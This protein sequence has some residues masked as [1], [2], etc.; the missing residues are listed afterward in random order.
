MRA[1]SLPRSHLTDLPISPTQVGLSSLFSSCCL[2]SPPPLPSCATALTP[3]GP[4]TFAARRA[5]LAATLADEGHAAYVSEPSANTLFYANLSASSWHLSERPFLLVTLPTTNASSK[6]EPTLVVVP[7][8][9]MT[10]AKLQLPLALDPAST[11]WLP[12]AEAED[13]YASL[14][15]Y[16]APSASAAIA[17]GRPVKVVVDENVRSGIAADLEAS[18]ARELGT[19]VRVMSSPSG[20]R[21]LRER[22]TTEEIDR[23][24]CAN[25]VLFVEVCPCRTSIVDMSPSPLP[26]SAHALGHPQ[27]EGQPRLWH[28]RARRLARP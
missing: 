11:I 15:A 25:E 19:D 16:L 24:V 7:S 12:W 14:A 5:R 13:P 17:A 28:D 20:I 8:F 22:K 18:L 10:R 27:H 3:L 2:H 1:C 26:P 4:A 9:E 23:L 6:S 21:T